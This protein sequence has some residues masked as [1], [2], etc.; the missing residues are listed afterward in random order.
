[1]RHLLILDLARVGTSRGTGT[2]RLMKQIRLIDSSVVVTVGGGISRIDEIA[3]LRDA[4]ANAV[5]VGSAI[6][7]GRIG[8]CELKELESG[9]IS[10]TKGN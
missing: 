10:G 8:A 4:G 6:H 1:V 2:G 7:D 9:A 3:A 5:L